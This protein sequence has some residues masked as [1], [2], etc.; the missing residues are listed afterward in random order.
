M[1]N[2]DDEMKV[3]YKERAQKYSNVLPLSI[4]GLALS[5]FSVGIIGLPIEIVNLIRIKKA[6]DEGYSTGTISAA[7]IIA[8]IGTVLGAFMTIFDIF[9]LIAVISQL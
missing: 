8:I 6:H 4:V 3:D 7:K 9:W 2:Y 5:A 1:T